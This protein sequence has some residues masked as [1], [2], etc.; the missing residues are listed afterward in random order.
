MVVP[1]MTDRLTVNGPTECSPLSSRFGFG[2]VITIPPFIEFC[3]ETT[4]KAKTHTQGC[5]ACE[6]KD[7][8][9]IIV[10]VHKH[11]FQPEL[12]TMI[13]VDIVP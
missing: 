3:Y 11:G 5:S 2:V 4:E 9:E 12:M 6:E 13:Y 7:T 10:S 1:P 8:G